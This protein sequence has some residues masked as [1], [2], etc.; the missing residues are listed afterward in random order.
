MGPLT[1]T[2]VSFCKTR[3]KPLKTILKSN[4]SFFLIEETIYSRLLNKVHWNNAQHPTGKHHLKLDVILFFVHLISFREAQA[5]DKSEHGYVPLKAEYLKNYHHQYK[6]YFQFLE[7][8]SFIQVRTY[9]ILRNQCKSYKIVKPPQLGTFI[10]HNPKDFV[11]KKKVQNDNVEKRL[12]ADKTTGHLTKWLSPDYLKID[13]DKAI[14]Y[15]SSTK[16]T[17]SKRYSRRFLVETIANGNFYYQRQGKDNRLH[18]II[19]NFPKDIRTFLKFN[20][21]YLV[22][23]DIKSSQP[24]MLAGLLNLIFI[25]NDIEKINNVLIESIKDIKIKRTIN[26]IIIIMIQESMSESDN[27]GVIQYINL[28]EGDIYN[29]LAANL[30]EE[31]R[32]D[33]QTPLGI[34]DSFYKKKLWYKVREHFDS[35]RDYCKRLMLEY[36]NCSPRNKEKRYLEVRRILPGE[37]SRIVDRF[38]EDDKNIFPIFLQNLESYLIL[39]KITKNIASEHPDIPLYTIHDSIVTTPQYASYVREQMEIELEGFFGIR[40]RIEEEPWTSV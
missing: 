4:I 5:K 34:T 39:D 30:S 38:K 25:T 2:P 37:I 18:S 15:I 1:A 21:S 7:E 6:V 22:S 29:H 14:D 3:N 32:N 26:N 36:L 10:Q 24:F 27:K 12:R 28:L 8:H 13:Y 11:L 40:P 20:D 19:T 16:M 17:H 9:S 35:M 23:L 31:L 33:I